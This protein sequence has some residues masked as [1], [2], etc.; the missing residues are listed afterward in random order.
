MQDLPPIES[1]GEA[2]R[3]QG[4]QHGR[5]HRHHGIAGEY[6]P[7]AQRRKPWILDKDQPVS[8]FGTI[9]KNDLGADP[10]I[11]NPTGSKT[12]KSAIQT[13][14]APWGGAMRV[15]MRLGLSFFAMSPPARPKTS[16]ARIAVGAPTSSPNKIVFPMSACRAATAASG[17]GCGG[18]RACDADKSGNERQSEPRQC[19]SHLFGRNFSD[20]DQQHQARLEKRP[21]ARSETRPRQT[22]APSAGPQTRG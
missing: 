13:P 5:Q 22:P 18:I 6:Q 17:P 4:E 14:G 9:G 21:A 20:G 10:R 2:K 19:H 1:A 8:R 7:T 12:M 11:I 16:Q 3:I 15:A